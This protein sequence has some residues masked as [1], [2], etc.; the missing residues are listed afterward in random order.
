MTLILILIMLILMMR[1]LMMLILRD[2]NWWKRMRFVFKKLLIEFCHSETRDIHFFLHC[3]VR[4]KLREKTNKAWQRIWSTSA[5]QNKMKFRQF[6]SISS[7]SSFVDVCDNSC[8]EYHEIFYILR[9]LFWWWIF[10]KYFFDDLIFRIDRILKLKNID[11]RCD[12]IVNNCSIAWFCSY[13][14][15][16]RTCEFRHLRQ[17]VVE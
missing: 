10:D 6:S 3:W 9:I 12:H 13:E 7:F 1:V 4:N 2:L 5:W 17:N 15:I 14:K 11:F 8:F 16:F